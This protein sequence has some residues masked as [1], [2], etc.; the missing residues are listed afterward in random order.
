MC[1]PDFNYVYLDYDPLLYDIEGE[2][3]KKENRWSDFN[4]R[5]V[6]FDIKR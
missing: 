1:F 2:N 3:Y 5:R 4:R 6:C